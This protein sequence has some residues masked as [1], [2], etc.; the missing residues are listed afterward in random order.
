MEQHPIARWRALAPPVSQAALAREIG[1]AQPSL[2]SI[3][4]GATQPSANTVRA[5]VAATE[6]LRPGRGLSAGQILGTELSPSPQSEEASAAA[7]SPAAASARPDPI[8]AAA[9]AE[10]AA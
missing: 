10:E 8:E 1:I 3:E 5:L 6:R 9:A 2:W 7:S 4:R